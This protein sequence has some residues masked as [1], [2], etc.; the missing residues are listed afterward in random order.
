MKCEFKINSTDK[1]LRA[2][3]LEE[4]GMAQKIVDS[5]VIRYCSPLVP[6]DT[7][8][9][10]KS[11]S[12]YTELGSG[13]IEYNTPYAR[14]QYHENSGTGQRGKLWFERMKADHKED[15]LRTAAQVTGGEA[16]K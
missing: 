1:I 2:R 10:E 15:I 14:K 3:N 4:A 16:K 13:E 6:F 9:L 12:L 7:G 8:M 11:A 5:E